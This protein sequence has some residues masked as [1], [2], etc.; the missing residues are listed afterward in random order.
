[1]NTKTTFII[2]DNQDI[3][4][5]GLYGYILT[6]FQA[7]DVVDVEHKEQLVA[8]LLKC[9]NA[10]VI[11]D[12]TLFDLKGVEG[13]LILVRR[14]PEVAWVLFSNEL[15]EDFLFR[16]SAEENI[17]MIL[18][19]S[20]EQE[21]CAALLAAERKERFLCSQITDFLTVGSRKREA[22]ASLTAT[23]TEILKMIAHGKSVKEIAAE[24][25]SSS[26]TIITH[27]KNIFR[28]LGVNNV[29]EATKFALRAGLMDRVE[30]YI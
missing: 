18:K 21:I 23:E 9:G 20:S 26:H 17:S 28:K 27:K 14:F 22:R 10:V 5:K 16:L 8:A 25:F 3:T 12:Y 1:M 15:S 4:K 19:E 2:A 6:T 11:L 29:Y 7:S 24:R 13:F 30:Y